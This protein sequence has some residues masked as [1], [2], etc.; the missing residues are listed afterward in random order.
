VV[1]NKKN[2]KMHGYGEEINKNNNLKKK[3]KSCI[4]ASENPSVKS[5]QKNSHYFVMETNKRMNRLLAALPS[6][7]PRM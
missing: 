1:A 4:F 5:W 7:H 2:E 6:P 3:R